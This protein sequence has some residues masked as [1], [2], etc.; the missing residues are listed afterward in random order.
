MCDVTY[1]VARVD[2]VPLREWPAQMRSALAALVP[3]EVRHPRRSQE[4]RPKGLNILGTFAHHPELAQAFFSFNGHV[5]LATTL[6]PRQRELLILRVAAV[7]EARY[8]W[9]QHVL[10]ALDA[11]LDDEEIR[12]IAVNPAGSSWSELE[13]ALLRSVD[14]LLG[15]GVI[16]DATW[17][18]LAGELDVRQVLDAVFTV[19]AYAT[20]ASMELSLGLELD[21]DLPDA[22]SLWL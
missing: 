5:Q 20:L 21:N 17:R 12:R 4:G 14:E 11:G 3:T 13:A 9:A 16:S 6:T 22:T 19:G 7:R 8:E 2:P 18:V 15:D 1:G 10:I